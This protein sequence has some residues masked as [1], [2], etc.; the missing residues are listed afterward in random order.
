MTLGSAESLDD[1]INNAP[2][3][4]V[5]DFYADWCGPCR[6]QGKIL[7]EMESQAQENDA[8]IIKVN[9]DQHPQLAEKYGVGSLPTLITIKGGNVLQRQTGLASSTKIASI[10]RL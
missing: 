4:V 3:V 2:G 5:V 8:T 7:H 1:K 9:V 10:L 6:R